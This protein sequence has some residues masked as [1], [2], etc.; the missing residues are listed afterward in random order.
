MAVNLDVRCSCGC[1]TAY[2]LT[3]SPKKDRQLGE[4]ASRMVCKACRQ[5]PATIHLREASA[6]AAGRAQAFSYQ[7]FPPL[8]H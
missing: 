3:R 5:R 8:M 7:L 2:R 1:E 6:V 4:V